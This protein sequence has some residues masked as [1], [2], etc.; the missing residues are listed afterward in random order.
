L[1]KRLHA[2]FLLGTAAVVWLEHRRVFQSAGRTIP[3]FW[4]DTL[5]EF[6]LLYHAV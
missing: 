5:R 4:A 1:T 6:D 3:Q 2:A